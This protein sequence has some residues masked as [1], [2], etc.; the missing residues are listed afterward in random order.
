[1]EDCIASNSVEKFVGFNLVKL[2]QPDQAQQAKHV[3]GLRGQEEVA[4][5]TKRN[6][7]D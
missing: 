4:Q 6:K 3:C 2:G 7:P 5:L 1:M